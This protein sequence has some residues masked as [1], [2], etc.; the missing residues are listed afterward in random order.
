MDNKDVEKFFAGLV[1]FFGAI[2]SGVQAV[3]DALPP[4]V[5]GGLVFV[6]LILWLF[7]KARHG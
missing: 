6:L 3:I 5:I 1:D 2:F 7:R 4:I